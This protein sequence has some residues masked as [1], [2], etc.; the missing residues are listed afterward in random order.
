MV[1]I[2]IHTAIMLFKFSKTYTNS[3]LKFAS[4]L[5]LFIG[6]T[7]SSLA[8]NPTGISSQ[9]DYQILSDISYGEY[10][11]NK[12]DLYLPAS[13]I[14]NMPLVVFFHGGSFKKGDKRQIS[15]Q[16]SII[17]NLLNNNIAFASVNYRFSED[18]DSLGVQKCINDA[19]RF[20]QFIRFHAAE[21][22]IDK[23]KIGCYGESAGAGISLYLAF[24]DDLAIHD[25]IGQLQQESTRIQCAGAIA[26]QATYNLLRWRS[27]IP[28]LG[29][30]YPFVKGQA[31]NPLANFYGYK[32]YK[33]FK[34]FR[35]E[36]M[37][38][39]DMLEM[40]S[41]DDPP[42]WVY[43]PTSDKIKKGIPFNANQLFHH[44]AHAKIIEK[45]AK[46]A[47][48]TYYVIT[49]DKKRNSTLS[50]DAFFIKYLSQ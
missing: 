23:N 18:N 1:P 8:Q 50:I 15:R 6:I 5:F 2:M 4:I 35:K 39:L 40:I 45:E 26:T 21:F 7:V 20:I 36:T 34:S 46:K 13:T 3:K 17:S 43:N 16:Y 10:G 49:N 32:T 37:T 41:P 25:S 11:Q 31:K 22:R 14:P 19:L 27:Y 48:I 47:N 12:F 33:A 24:H 38:K 44:P 9:N 29:L 42:V 28:G 30:L